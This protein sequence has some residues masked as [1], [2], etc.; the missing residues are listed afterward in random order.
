MWAVGRLS[1][2]SKGLTA[3]KAGAAPAARETARVP[4][5]VTPPT[6]P[7]S[8][9]KPE[10]VRSAPVPP[11]SSPNPALEPVATSS[12]TPG[13]VQRMVARVRGFF[14]SLFG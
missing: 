9:P 13:L 3:G 8:A 5:P 11:L 1:L 7:V 6:V 2:L 14:R 4:S 10:P 12:P